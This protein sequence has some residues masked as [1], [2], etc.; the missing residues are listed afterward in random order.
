MKDSITLSTKVVILGGFTI[1]I[2]GFVS[3]KAFFTW[4]TTKIIPF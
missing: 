4:K 1:F 3:S 2:I